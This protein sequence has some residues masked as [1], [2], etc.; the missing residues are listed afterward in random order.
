MCTLRALI[1]S[2]FSPVLQRIVLSIL[3]REFTCARDIGFHQLIVK[4]T[5]EEP[6][7]VYPT[8]VEDQ[9]FISCPA[10]ELKVQ[11]YSLG[12]SLVHEQSMESFNETFQ[13][14]SLKLEPGIYILKG[15]YQNG[16]FTRKVIVR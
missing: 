5:E 12:G 4:L 10:K 7:S 16:A 9:I 13:I 1:D 3:Q 6:V 15:S 11:L 2:L 8:L 14:G